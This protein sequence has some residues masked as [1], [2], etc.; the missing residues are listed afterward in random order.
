MFRARNVGTFWVTCFPLH[1]QVDTFTFLVFYCTDSKKIQN[2]YKKLLRVQ[3]S[4]NLSSVALEP[5]T[6]RYK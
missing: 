5:G 6:P 2:S 1:C 4:N 3:F